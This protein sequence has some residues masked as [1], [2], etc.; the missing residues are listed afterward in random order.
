[1]RTE[2]SDSVN[3]N[4]ILS[5]EENQRAEQNK[6]KIGDFVFERSEEMVLDTISSQASSIDI[7]LNFKNQNFRG[8]VL[9]I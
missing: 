6:I 4:R 7:V 1:M 5:T 8:Q 3:V 2:L 9:R